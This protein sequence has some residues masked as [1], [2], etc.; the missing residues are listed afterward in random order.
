LFFN[1]I[2]LPGLSSLGL[3]LPCLPWPCLAFLG[4]AFPSLALEPFLE[5]KTFFP[6]YFSPI[7]SR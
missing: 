2:A 4:L 3:A 5:E 7:N 6:F 1:F